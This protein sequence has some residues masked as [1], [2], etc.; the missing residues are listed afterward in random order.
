M[1][2]FRFLRAASTRVSAVYA[3][4]FLLTCLSLVYLPQWFVQV[5]LTTAEIGT[6]LAV[7][8]VVKVPLT[9]VF[10]TTADMLANR[11]GVLLF[12]SALLVFAMPV[13]LVVRDWFWLC[14]TWALIGG[15][16]STCIPLT[17]SVAVNTVRRDGASYGRMR[18]WG[19]LSF[20]LVSLSA[21]WLIDDRGDAALIYLLIIGAL[22]VWLC[23][24]GL[25]RHE[26]LGQSAPVAATPADAAGNTVTR[27]P[28][29][30]GF[31]LMPV[32]RLPG[33]LLFLVV[34]AT[35]MASHAAL[36]SLSTVYWVAAGI[37]LPV[38]GILWATGV[39]AE[40]GFFFIARTLVNQWSPWQLL[41]IAGVAG[42]LRWSVT[43]VA[44]DVSVLLVTQAMHAVTF[45]FTQLAVV[46]YIG[47]RVPES[48]TSSAQ[49]LYDSCALGV[50][51]GAALYVSGSLSRIDTAWSFRAM[52]VMSAIGAAVALVQVLRRR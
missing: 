41:L 42:A 14:V 16:I 23:V 31:T 43:A 50:V 48:L 20:L 13:L 1:S 45:T 29:N 46:T 17:D 15:L 10:G 39:V 37:S 47:N 5:G 26:V 9:L 38:I 40:I 30:T 3:A 4:L 21:G 24:L 51:F 44:T 12:V 28:V 6:I 8:A 36:Y 49:S 18:M 33:F 34:A 11:K 52:A 27:S 25:P 35:L 19:S 32:V 2:S 7:A 22:L